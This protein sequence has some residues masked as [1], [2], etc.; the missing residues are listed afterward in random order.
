MI[1]NQSNGGYLGLR[2]KN[3]RRSKKRN[4]DEIDNDSIMDDL[5]S[6]KST[7]VNKQNVDF[8]REKLKST[9]NYRVEMMRDLSTDLLENFPFFFSNP[10]MVITLIFIS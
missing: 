2:Q 9:L 6:L 1:Y 5:D 8:I 7:V 3:S 10:E 4:H